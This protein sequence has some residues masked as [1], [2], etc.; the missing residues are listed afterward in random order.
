MWLRRSKSRIRLHNASSPKF[1]CSS[2]KDIQILLSE[3]DSGYRYNK[4]SAGDGDIALDSPTPYIRKPSICHRVRSSNF[5]LRTLS[6]LPD[7]SESKPYGDEGQVPAPLPENVAADVKSEPV[8]RIPRAENIIMVYFTSLRILRHTFEDCKTVL[9]ILRSFNVLVDE[10]DVSMDSGYIKELQKIFGEP[11]KSKLTL[12]RVF[13]GGRYIGGAEEVRQLHESGELKK[14]LQ[15]LLPADARGCEACGGYRFILC[16]ECNGSH[17]YYSEKCGFKSCT[18]CNE[19]GL[20][21]CPSC[22]CASF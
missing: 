21:R 11:E 15:G 1:A 10:R 2:L 20:T 17:K 6:L 12:P 22:S 4:I 18:S 16:Q 5:L 9:T 8:I 13:I 3:E 14:Y 7:H 19:N